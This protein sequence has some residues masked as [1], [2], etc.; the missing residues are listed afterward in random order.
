MTIIRHVHHSPLARL[1]EE[2]C[3]HHRPSV[4]LPDGF[5]LHADLQPSLWRGSSFSAGLPSSPT[6][7][8]CLW[9]VCLSRSSCLGGPS[10]WPRPLVLLPDGPSK[11]PHP[12]FCHRA[13][14]LSGPVCLPCH[15]V[16]LPHGPSCLSCHWAVLLSW[17][18]NLKL[19]PN[20]PIC[21]EIWLTESRAALG[22]S[23]IGTDV[24]PVSLL[25]C[26]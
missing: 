23:N 19:Q 10:K 12:E 22:F 5:H 11:W 1:L 6:C 24:F 16:V 17:A 21:A 18:T 7:H 13:I 25:R 14:L 4:Q 3:L 9:D 8:P 2:L 26:M 15:Q 20:Y